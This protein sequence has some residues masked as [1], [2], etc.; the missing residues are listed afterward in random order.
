MN[1]SKNRGTR[2]ETM[3]VRWLCER[4]GDDRIERRALHGSKDMGDIYGL[5]CHGNAEG[6]VECKAHS[7]V[8]PSKVAEWQRQT[9]D[10]QAN[11]GAD[12][13]LLAIKTPN[14]G[15]KSLGRTRVR[16]TTASLMAI[17]GVAWLHGAHDS[18]LSQWVETD[19]ETVCALM[20]GTA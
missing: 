15:P 18:A 8:T 9:E 6:I 10:E 7:E 11:A 16:L 12:F 13:A 19:L 3:V 1:R 4:L 5:V 2:F 14:V 17:S 20:E